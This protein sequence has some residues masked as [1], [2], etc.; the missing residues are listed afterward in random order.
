MFLTWYKECRI[1]MIH[2]TRSD[3]GN[4]A[5]FHGEKKPWKN[6]LTQVRNH[7]AKLF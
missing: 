2:M 4:N 7:M 3:H 1:P 5:Q 6:E